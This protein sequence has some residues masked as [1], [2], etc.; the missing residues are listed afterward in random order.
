MKPDEI[1]L[2][3]FFKSY[4][5]KLNTYDIVEK[6]F[7][8]QQLYSKSIKF[9]CAVENSGIVKIL[10]VDGL[11]HI[12]TPDD[13]AVMLSGHTPAKGIHVSTKGAFGITEAKDYNL[14]MGMYVNARKIECDAQIETGDFLSFFS[15][16]AS[17]SIN[18]QQPLTTKKLRI[19]APKLIAAAKISADASGIDTKLLTIAEKGELDIKSTPENEELQEDAIHKQNLHTDGKPDSDFF[20]D[21]QTPNISEKDVLLPSSCTKWRKHLGKAIYKRKTSTINVEEVITNGTL[22]FKHVALHVHKKILFLDNSRSTFESVGLNADNLQV[23]KYAKV[24]GADTIMYVKTRFDVEGEIDINRLYVSTPNPKVCG[25]LSGGEAL[26]I[27]NIETAHSSGII[28]SENTTLRGHYLLA[29]AVFA[30]EH[31]RFKYHFTGGIVGTK[32]LTIDMLSTIITSGAY[33]YGPKFRLS[34]GLYINALG[35]VFSYDFVQTSNCKFDYGLKTICLPHELSDLFNREKATRAALLV[36]DNVPFLRGFANVYALLSSDITTRAC[37]SFRDDPNILR[38]FMNASKAGLSAATHAAQVSKQVVTILSEL[39]SGNYDT[40]KI[41]YLSDTVLS[42]QG[43]AINGHMLVNN[44]TGA[45]EFS[46]RVL[47]RKFDSF[48]NIFNE[49][50]VRNIGYCIAPSV[51]STSLFSFDGGITVT[52]SVLDYSLVSHSTSITA[53]PRISSHALYMSKAGLT[54]GFDVNEFALLRYHSGSTSARHLT[55]DVANNTECGH[56]SASR[57]F[58]FR[59]GTNKVEKGATFESQKE[60]SGS[61]DNFKTDGKVTLTGGNVAVKETLE[62]G[63]TGDLKVDHMNFEAKKIIDRGTLVEDTSNVSYKEMEVDPDA[64]LTIKD[65]R[66]SGEETIWHPGSEIEAKRS[67]VASN[68]LDEQGAEVKTEDALFQGGNIARGGNWQG[69]EGLAFVADKI[70]STPESRLKTDHLET[71]ANDADL[72]GPE[73]TKTSVLDVKNMPVS[74][75]LQYINGTDKHADK[76]ISEHLS[77]RTEQQGAIDLNSFMRGPDVGIAVTA[78]GEINVNSPFRGRSLGLH[79]TNESVNLRSNI[80]TDAD[81]NI[82]AKKHI[83]KPGVT[84]ESLKGHIQL[85]AQEG[86]LDNDNGGHIIAHTGNTTAIGA[87]FSNRTNGTARV[88]TV[89]GDRVI[90]QSTQETFDVFKGLLKAKTVL[91]I[92]SAGDFNLQPEVVREWLSQHEMGNVYYGSVLQGGTGTEDNGGVGLVLRIEGKFTG[93][94]SSISSSGKN[95]I[96]VDQDFQGETKVTVFRSE[97]RRERHGLFGNRHYFTSD[98]ARQFRME[99]LS[100]DQNIIHS[101]GGRVIDIGMQTYAPNGTEIVSQNEMTARPVSYV[102]HSSHNRN[103]HFHES[104]RPSQNGQEANTIY[105]QNDGVTSFT[106]NGSY[107]Y[108]LGVIYIGSHDSKFTF[109]APQGVDIIASVLNNRTQSTTVSAQLSM[110]GQTLNGPGRQ[111]N[112][113]NTFY[114]LDPTSGALGNFTR[115]SNLP[116]ALVNGASSI[117]GISDMMQSIATNGLLSTLSKQM[118]AT[119]LLSRTRTTFDYQMLGASGFYGGASI[120]ISTDGVATFATNAYGT[121][122]IFEVKAD[123]FRL[124]N[125]TLHSRYRRD[126][127]SIAPSITLSGRCDVGASYSQQTSHNTVQVQRL[128]DIGTFKLDVRRLH[129]RGTLVACKRMTGRADE[130]EMENAHNIFEATQTQVSASMQ[131]N[132]GGSHNHSKDETQGAKAGILVSDGIND[133]DDTRLLV[134]RVIKHGDSKISSLD[135]DTNH[136]DAEEILVKETLRSQQT[137]G[138][139]SANFSDRKDKPLPTFSTNYADSVVNVTP[140]GLEVVRERKFQTTVLIPKTTPKK[141]ESLIKLGETNQRNALSGKRPSIIG[142]ALNQLESGDF[143]TDPGYKYGRPSSANGDSEVKQSP[144]PKRSQEPFSFRDLGLN[145]ED[146]MP[147]QLRS[148]SYPYSPNVVSGQFEISPFTPSFNNSRGNRPKLTAA[149]I[150]QMGYTDPMELVED[151]LAAQQKKG[152]LEESPVNSAL[153]GAGRAF[154]QTGQGATQFAMQV[155]EK[156][157]LVDGSTLDAYNDKITREHDLYR[158]T[159]VGNSLSGD[160]GEFAGEMLLFSVIPGGAAARGGK[161]ALWGATSGAVV[162]GLQPV[163]HGDLTQRGINTLVGAA[164]GAVVTPA[165]A[166]A[167]DLGSKAIVTLY[168]RNVLVSNNLARQP[169]RLTKGQVVEFL[170]VVDTMP[171][172]QLTQEFQRFGLELYEPPIEGIYKLIHWRTDIRRAHEIKGGKEPIYS[173]VKPKLENSK[174]IIEFH[175]GKGGMDFDHMHIT[176]RYGN[177]YDKNLNNLTAKYR[178]ENPSWHAGKLKREVEGLPEAHIRIKEFVE[179]RMRMNFE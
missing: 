97:D 156:V 69:T 42:I 66:T 109:N 50:L 141:E 46:Q 84:V 99:I 37:K 93:T 111:L 64:H 79:S 31:I 81:V 56:T 36:A 24:Y 20:F 83:F 60:T 8:Y 123:E 75:V 35:G 92:Y 171:L 26:Y 103:R 115:S 119:L 138:G 163:Y 155:G 128:L 4:Q 49:A 130:I 23:D 52:G 112:P 17:G 9:E 106:S 162:T 142:E 74:E 118:G 18:V 70:S 65:S 27:D 10:Y 177:I 34:S 140:N 132:V 7:T 179:L 136:L 127:Y 173:Y 88:S 167:V 117:Y 44:I 2:R 58:R 107:I 101:I 21:L 126:T 22:S 105:A 85:I 135:P 157:G 158:S 86:T 146:R 76:E 41:K 161:L 134:K 116:E 170:Q 16:D 168:V 63:K 150:N 72:Q 11:L 48:G 19:S 15:N 54:Y 1:V 151:L 80:S 129:N 169:Q 61:T 90:A 102:L 178:K 89:Y 153:I 38:Q 110:F 144:K 160:F 73:S 139:F 87:K 120:H 68:R 100:E 29:S 152:P 45:T 57:S 55:L 53:A 148:Q 67:V 175:K 149:N 125:T 77:V 82:F 5:P 71:H 131:G 40:A 122:P 147:Q 96:F 114:H 39:S 154:V 164:S 13:V 121:I 98:S 59:F 6:T 12:D 137:G 124:Y 28:H 165:V 133:S 159:P 104:R 62:V 32:S 174:F 94:A 166:K 143:L 3:L 43:L 78:P 172:E 30:N 113:M 95:L 25:V 145:T 47:S 51:F 14:D 91:E 176:D 33:F 108:H